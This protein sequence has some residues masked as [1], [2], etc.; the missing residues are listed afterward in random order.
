MKWGKKNDYPFFINELLNGSALQGGIVKAK[1]NY[2]AGGGL[3]IV[4]GG[5]EV[6]QFIENKYVD[7]DM[8]EILQMVST[9]HECYG[10][11]VVKGSWS[12][13]GSKVVK[14]EHLNMDDCRF[15]ED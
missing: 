1:V 8:N 7:F 15:S 13:D 12:K 6:E 14:W 4:S 10:G 9:D 3:E 5:A 2:V 11:F